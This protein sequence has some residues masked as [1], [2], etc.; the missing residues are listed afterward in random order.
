M[1]YGKSLALSQNA[2]VQPPEETDVEDDNRSPSSKR[3]QANVYDAVSGR[4]SFHGFL[5]ST[6]HASKYRDTFS[7]TS[8]AVRPEE[9]LFRRHQ[10]PTRYEENDFYFAHESLP[11]E[12]TLPSSDLLEAVHAY[13]ADFYEYATIDHGR[14]DHHSMDETALI[15]TGILLEELA[16]ESLGKT[17]DL[18]L[19]EG[20]EEEEEDASDGIPSR[21]RIAPKG[22]RKRANTGLSGVTTTSGDDLAGVR[23][24]IKKRRLTPKASMTDLDT[25]MA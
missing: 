3:R 15:A 5:G 10:A 6:P 25:E 22:G 9:V 4:V 24:K 11:S 16:K 23:K 21:R 2:F 20:E 7:S 19:V 8:L 13:A 14:D 12:K 1:S 18:V 17:G